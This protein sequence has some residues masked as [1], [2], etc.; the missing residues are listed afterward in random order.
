MV[1]MTEGTGEMPWKRDENNLI[2]ELDG[3]PVIVYPDGKEAPFNGDATILAINKA[4]GE[5]QERRLE[6]KKINATFSSLRDA[7]VEFEADKISEFVSN[8]I[9]NSETVQ[10]FDDKDFI[11][12][13]KVKDITDKAIANMETSYKKRIEDQQTLFANKEADY[14]KKYD[15]M[16][17]MGRKLLIE[18]EFK[19]SE[20]LKE[21]I[22]NVPWD[23]FYNTY[24]KSFSVEHDSN[25]KATVK[26]QR[27]DGTDVIS[28]S[29]PGQFADPQ[30][31]IEILINEHP[32]KDAFM[33]GFQNGGAGS[34]Q[35]QSNSTKFIKTVRASDRDA[36]SN[37][38]IQKGIASGEIRVE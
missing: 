31:A 21:Q 18:S 29:K 17:A 22:P 1:E 26:A 36:M 2:I 38:E 12:A 34:T 3:N 33:V 6:L 37:P 24:E 5:A 13:N 14:L 25:G 9:K 15:Q 19:S 16:D 4:N 35:S 32:Q 11:A 7:G 20:F 23:F 28:L 30:E 10:N 27:P 8:A